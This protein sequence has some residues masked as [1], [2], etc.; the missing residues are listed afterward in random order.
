[1]FS[2]PSGVGKTSLGRVFSKAILCDNP[3]DGN[4]CCSCESCKLFQEEKHF[5]YLEMD[6]AS[7]GGKED[8]IKLRDEASFQALGKKKIILLDECHDISRQGQDALLK[9]VEQCPEHLIYIFCTTE[10]EKVAPTLRK[11]CTHFQFSHVPSNQIFERLKKVCESENIECDEDALLMI[12]ERSNGHVRD[13]LKILEE[14]AYFGRV[15]SDNVSRIILD[16]SV[17]IYEILAGLGS[18]VSR[19][20]SLSRELTSYISVKELY[21]QMISMVNDAVKCLYGYEDFLPARKDLLIRLRDIHGSNLLEFLNYLISRDKYIDQVGFQSDI[22]LLH[23]K[24]CSGSFKPQIPEYGE[25][26][27]EPA[28]K[29][30]NEP[31][32]EPLVTHAQLSKMSV[33]ERSKLLREQRRTHKNPEGEQ[34]QRVPVEWSLPKEEIQG[35]SSFDEKE[36]SPLEFSRLLVGGR[37]SGTV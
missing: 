13:S 14:V 4:P 17:K 5:G 15:D 9:Q 36:L 3:L 12:A 32:K 21:A 31:T 29:N 26:T 30:T 34:P 16:Y 10:P 23:Y 2:G 33:K 37:G 25:K 18:N 6:A 8:M 1:M 11:R 22:I 27:P 19:S 7:C 28:S 20:L 35:A 24:F